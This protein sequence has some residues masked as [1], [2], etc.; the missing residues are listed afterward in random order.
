MKPGRGSLVK[1]GRGVVKSR[2]AVLV[3][4]MTAT[5]CSDG[6]TPPVVLPPTNIHVV[7]LATY[8][9]SGEAVHPDVANTPA[10]WDGDGDKKQL[11]VTPYPN[12]DAS[13]ENPSLFTRTSSLEWLVPNGV[14]NPIARPDIGYLSDPDQV[15]NPE[16]NE[17]WLYYRGVTTQNEI[18]LIR[19]SGPSRWSAPELVASAPNHSI[20]SPS[21]VRRGAGD[22]LMWAVNSGSG[23]CSGASTTVELRRSSDGIVWSAPVTADL[24]ETGVFPWHIDVEWI[25]SK[26]EF[27]AT[28]NVKIPGSC[29]TAA[30]HFAK[31]ADGLHWTPAAGSV[32]ERSAIPEFTDIVYRASLEYDQ[33]S[34]RITLW[35]SGAHYANSRYTWRIATEELSAADFFARI[36]SPPIPGT[37][38][39][40]TSAPP[41]TDDDAP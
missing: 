10:G 28:Y 8:D 32:L 23:G 18:F 30:L 3:A 4:L 24:P 37:G 12:G 31:S 13:K 6:S 36:A 26:Q 2:G 15:F 9:G 29:T 11:F 39:G 5:A 22:W 19:G 17:L 27:W 1:P 14:M 41:L 20:V 38:L 40:V 35:Y 7:A 21:V 33:V 25:P 16:T 34:D